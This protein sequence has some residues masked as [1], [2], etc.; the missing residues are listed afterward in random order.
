MQW[1]WGT[2]RNGSS[3]GVGCCEDVVEE[4][5]AKKAKKLVGRIAGDGEV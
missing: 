2:S 3:W 5:I 1:R 4:G